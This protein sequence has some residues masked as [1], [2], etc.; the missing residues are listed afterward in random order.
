[1]SRA[2]DT[3]RAGSSPAASD[4]T[5]R[6]CVWGLWLGLLLA[7]FWFVARHASTIPL[8]DDLELVPFAVGEVP[9]RPADLWKQHNEHRIPLAKWILTL[10]VRWTGDF[11]A[12][13]VMS[14]LLLGAASAATLVVARRLRGRA[15]FTDAVFPLAWLHLGHGV[16][17]LM[18]FQLALVLPVAMVTA[19]LLLLVRR[20]DAPSRGAL[21]AVALAVLLLPFNGGAGALY[22][23]VWAGCL[24]ALGLS[25]LVRGRRALASGALALALATGGLIAVYAAG[26]AQRDEL[27]PALERSQDLTTQLATAL[28]FL[29][30]SFGPSARSWWPWSGWL[31]FALTALTLA[32]LVH[33][34]LSRPDERWRAV[35]LLASIGGVLAAA[36]AIG[37]SRGGASTGFASRYVI[38]VVPLP[39]ALVLAWQLYLAPRVARP[40]AG[41]LAA[42]LLLALVPNSRAG[43]RAGRYRRTVHTRLVADVE[44]GLSTRQ[45]AREHW[46]RC[47]SSTTVFAGHL[48]TLRAARWAP[49][50][51]ATGPDQRLAGARPTYPML[52]TAPD[53]IEAPVPPLKRR[54]DGRSVLL[55]PAGTHLVYERAPGTTRLRGAYGVP[56]NAW[57][58]GLSVTVKIALESGEKER[59]LLER[60]LAPATRVTDRGVHEFDVTLPVDAS[61]RLVLST[62]ATDDSGRNAWSFWT[63]IELD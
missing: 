23:A 60:E 3:P 29:A 28:R 22:A 15:S 35:A 2:S 34:A 43:L 14:T 19:A 31:V 4:R 48:A 24:G 39:C 1:M 45:L 5:A 59:V 37:W 42:T 17:L 58:R 55:V 30:L 47:A 63:E 46:K 20:R 57:E 6:L 50:E 52:V 61:G 49:Y 41:L 32:R 25:E 9:L 36:L 11:R 26:L 7:A 44:R 51:D 27:G 53:E 38:L 10:A 18:G 33:V 13:M 12:P 16:N 56:P 21:L 8:W 62:R 54:I 40:A